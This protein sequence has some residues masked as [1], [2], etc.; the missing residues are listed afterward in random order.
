MMRAGERIREIT[1]VFWGF[2]ADTVAR[3]RL[4]PVA[5]RLCHG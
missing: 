3:E 2:L 1:G 5:I 4:I